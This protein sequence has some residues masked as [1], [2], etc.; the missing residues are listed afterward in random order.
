MKLP[1][2]AAALVLL[3]V[4]AFALG[5]CGFKLRGEQ[6]MPFDSV[7]IPPNNPLLTELSRYIEFG[8]NAKVV[9]TP[10]DAQATVGLLA[11]LQEKVIVALNTKGQVREY[12]LRYRVVFRVSSPKGF[13]Y[14]PPTEIIL[15][16]DITFNDQVLAKENEEALLYRDMRT[17]MVQQ[18]LRRI[19]AS[20]PP[21]VDPD[22]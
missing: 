7:Y 6:Q 10:Q 20:R 19:A 3:L 13:D 17:D 12:T 4:A 22:E 1:A 11:E 9:N 16:R 2:R 8:S 21:A 15:N 14:L 18:M 5:G